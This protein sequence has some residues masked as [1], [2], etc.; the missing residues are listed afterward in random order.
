[1]LFSSAYFLKFANSIQFLFKTICLSYDIRSTCESSFNVIWSVNIWTWI[2][3]LLSLQNKD[4]L[5]L[6]YNV[7]LY[8]HYII[9]RNNLLKFQLLKRPYVITQFSFFFLG[10]DTHHSV[11]IKA[12]WLLSRTKSIL[13]PRSLGWQFKADHK[14]FYVLNDN[15]K[16]EQIIIHVV[17]LFD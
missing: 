7:F 5:V 12:C 11:K 6:L 4:L 1:M 9:S 8:M 14:F 10:H 16:I 15:T 2:L 3:F 17:P 13:Q